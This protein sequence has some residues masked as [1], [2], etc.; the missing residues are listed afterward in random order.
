[1]FLF[2]LRPCLHIFCRKG[3]VKCFL[4]ALHACPGRRPSHLHCS[5]GGVACPPFYQLLLHLVPPP[6]QPSPHEVHGVDD[7]QHLFLILDTRLMNKV[8]ML[9]PGS[10]KLPLFTVSGHTWKKQ[11]LALPQNNKNIPSFRASKFA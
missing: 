10:L 4:P 3:L 6:C 1:M 9:V 11:I 5:F 8:K 7:V 2:I